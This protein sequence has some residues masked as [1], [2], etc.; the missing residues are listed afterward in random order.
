MVSNTGVTEHWDGL[1]REGVESPSLEIFKTQL[2]VVL[3]NLL[4]VTL[5]EQGLD[6]MTSRRPCPPQPCCEGGLCDWGGAGKPGLLLSALCWL[7]VVFGQQLGTNSA[8]FSSRKSQCFRVAFP[9]LLW[10]SGSGVRYPHPTAGFWPHCS[11][12]AAAA[13]E[14]DAHP[15]G[16]WCALLCC[17]WVWGT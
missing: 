4:K 6:W 1:P 11:A 3:D 9:W 17:T 14:V 16:P 10:G 5:L 13:V 15:F 8:H 7:E 2:D 12:G